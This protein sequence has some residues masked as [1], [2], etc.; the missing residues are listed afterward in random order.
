MIVVIVVLAVTFV[1]LVFSYFYLRLG[2]AD[3]WPP[4]GVTLPAW[5]WPAGAAV[6]WLSS[7]VLV[8]SASRALAGGAIT[9]FRALLMLGAGLILVAAAL[10]G[11]GQLRA[12]LAPDRHAY[13]ATV[14]TVI[15]VQ[16]VTA[17][18]VL[19]M[20]GL[21]ARPLVARTTRPGPPRHVRQHQAAL[22]L[23]GG[24]GSRRSRAHARDSTRARLTRSRRMRF[25]HPARA[26]APTAPGSQFARIALVRAGGR[27]SARGCPAGNRS[28]GRAGRP[29]SWRATARRNAASPPARAA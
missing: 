1:S 10:D 27:C 28:S 24:A 23:H 4:P 13:G 22:A 29:T 15:V 9:G 8:A 7:S 26:G 20:A 2:A 3:G 11:L 16:G 12:G 17:L 21:H 18:A 19:M 14:A 25:P 5:G 6:T